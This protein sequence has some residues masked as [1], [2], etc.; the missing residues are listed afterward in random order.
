MM[1]AY[2]LH[3]AIDVRDVADAHLSALTN[4]GVRFERYIISASTPFAVSDCDHLATDAAS[5]I[6]L[7]SPTLAAEFAKRRWMLPRS[8]DRVYSAA[9]AE[10]RLGWRSRFGFEEVL[11]QM[12][13]QSLELLPFGSRINTKSE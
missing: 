6:A 2:R 7:R 13:M 10:D 12:D 5:V 3:R 11:A 8:I 9:L 4:E 1:A